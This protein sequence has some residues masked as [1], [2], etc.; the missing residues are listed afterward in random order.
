[1]SG[2]IQPLLDDSL[3]E[4][5]IGVVGNDRAA[6]SVAERALFLGDEIKRRVRFVHN[7]SAS[8]D[9]F[10][11]KRIFDAGQLGALLRRFSG[12]VVRV[13][14]SE[15]TLLDHAFGVQKSRPFQLEGKGQRLAVVLNSRFVGGKKNG[16]V[17]QRVVDASEIDG[18]AEERVIAK[19]FVRGMFV[20]AV[21]PAGLGKTG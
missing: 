8:G 17:E 7:P 9:I 19:S 21:A 10:R 2:R 15:E 6:G 14:V 5:E 16:G 1:M 3:G 4:R 13:F 18:L 11:D 12:F 20:I